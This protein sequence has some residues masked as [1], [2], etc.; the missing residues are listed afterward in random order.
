MY[1]KHLLLGQRPCIYNT[2]LFPL[3][4]SVGD[5]G[6][7]NPYKNYS[8]NGDVS[9]PSPVIIVEAVEDSGTRA[10]AATNARMGIKRSSGG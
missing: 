8:N 9:I 5:G 6:V 2:N 4:V 1:A 7:N 3:L 10:A